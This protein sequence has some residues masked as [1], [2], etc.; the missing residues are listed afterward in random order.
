MQNQNQQRLQE[1]LP[2]N[3]LSDTYRWFVLAHPNPTSKQFSTQT[4]VH[5][6]EVAEMIEEIRPLSAKADYLLHD[7]KVALNALAT[8]LKQNDGVITVLEGNLPGFLDALCDQIVT[9]TGVGRDCGF[10][11]VE[12]MEEVNAS[13]WSK[14][15]EDGK[16][17]FDSNGKI[18]KGPN[19]FKPNLKQFIPS[20]VPAATE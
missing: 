4:G 20:L 19:Y 12:A 7:A 13:N 2:S 6:E 11:M 17:N 9:A 16:P 18:T 1:K 5:F 15:D 8:Y 10:P 14:F 3:T